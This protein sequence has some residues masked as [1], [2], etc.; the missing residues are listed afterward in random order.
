MAEH[1]STPRA[2][3]PPSERGEH[4]LVPS[5]ARPLVVLILLGVVV[6]TIIG[7]VLIGVVAGLAILVAGGVLA[8]AVALMLGVIGARSQL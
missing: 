7:I 5:W 6:A 1:R 4:R 2:V 8:T 3:R